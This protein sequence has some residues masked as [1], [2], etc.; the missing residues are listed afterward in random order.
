MFVLGF[1]YSFAREKI[2]DEYISLK[3][4]ETFS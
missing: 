2:E 4:I 1:S 3:K